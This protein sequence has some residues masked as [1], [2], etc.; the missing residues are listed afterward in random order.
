MKL[1]DKKSI[2]FLRDEIDCAGCGVL[3]GVELFAIKEQP[4][5]GIQTLCL[6][7][8]VTEP[9]VNFQGILSLLYPF[10]VEIQ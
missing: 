2:F 3:G 5:K 8:C 6:I 10:L 7:G 1:T 9:F 4:S